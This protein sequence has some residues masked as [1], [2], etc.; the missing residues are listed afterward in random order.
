MSENARIRVLSVDDHPLMREGLAALINDAPD[1][2][3]VAEATNGTDAM[4]EFRAHRPD[5]TVM[6]L[7]LPDMSGIDALVA[8]R[9][10]FP[11]ARVVVLT[12]F[13]GDAEIARAFKEG[14]A[15]YFLKTTPPKDLREA[16]RQVHAG[17][18]TVPRDV[19]A[20]LVDQLREDPLTPREISVLQEVAAGGGNREIGV[21][22]SIAEETVKVHMKKVLEKLGAVDRTQAL[23]IA[24]RRGIIHL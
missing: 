22:L 3:L 15:G 24:L 14:A 7:R 8:I 6:D 17:E 9:K 10:E 20:R 12:T 21:R 4:R 11:E 2:T 5:V 19:G 16:I 1:M 18:K 13:E 23:V